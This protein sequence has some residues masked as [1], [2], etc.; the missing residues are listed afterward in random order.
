MTKNAAYKT[1]ADVDE[2]GL[3]EEVTKTPVDEVNKTETNSQA[4]SVEPDKDVDDLEATDDPEADG[5]D[6]EDENDE[7]DD[8]DDDED[9]E[10]D[11]DD[12]DE[13]DDDKQV[14]DFESYQVKLKPELDQETRTALKLRKDQTSKRP[15][16]RRQEWHR[17]KRLG[18]KWRRPKGIHSKQRRG[19]RYREPTAKVGYGV[20]A[21]VSGLHPSGFQE[22]MVHTPTDLEVINAKTQ[23]ARIGRTDPAE[24]LREG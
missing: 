1:Q 20:P 13:D 5:N 21:A 8:W 16:F 12:E 17:Y 7:D 19:F 15:Q 23:A 4:G 2:Q 6:D 14:L 11:E 3:D 18:L 22:V 24:I 9:G 10:D